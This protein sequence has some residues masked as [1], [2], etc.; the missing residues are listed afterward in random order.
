MENAKTMPRSAIAAAAVGIVAISAVLVAASADE[1]SAASRALGLAIFWTGLVPGA[2]HLLRRDLS[3]L[4]I[5][6]VA[7][8]FYS[9]TFG[10]PV[11]FTDFI[12]PEG[13]SEYH[14]DVCYYGGYCFY[15]I[16]FESLAEYANPSALA[17]AFAGV[18]A[19]VASFI[20]C[21]RFA[22]PR[23]TLFRLPREYSDRRLFL[24]LWAFLAVALA[25]TWIPAL[26]RLPS[27][28]QLITPAGYLAF[29]M[30]LVLWL[31]GRLG[32]LHAVFVFVFGLGLFFSN[33]LA[34]G[35]IT[36]LMILA[37]F[38]CFVLL[39]LNRRAIIG[40]AVIGI[41]VLALVYPAVHTYRTFAWS[42]NPTAEDKS[43]S[44]GKKLEWLGAVLV[45]HWRGADKITLNGVTTQLPPLPAYRPLVRRL[46]LLPVFSHVHRVTPDP[47]PYWGGKTYK[48]LLTSFIPRALW[49]GKPREIFGAEFGY[50]YG[51]TQNHDTSINI[52]WLIELF[53][54]FGALGVMIGM[55]AI[56]MFLAALDRFFNSP[57]ASSLETVIGLAIIVPLVYPNSN[58]SLMVGSLLPLTVSL[59]VYF[60]VGLTWR[61]NRPPA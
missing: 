59:W 33:K 38:L 32:R 44:V 35:L 20:A 37:L 13:F 50:R 25:Y 3:A 16:N 10:L 45:A 5:F 58:F 56:G 31:Q 41:I 2:W 14:N 22:A 49:P 28:G 51:F 34:G 15:S 48:P 26:R 39:Y 1:I 40:F 6:P 54:N 12:W 42:Q 52:P 8:A 11:F 36:P 60:R 29:G 27:V 17:V 47:V 21:R 43:P 53:I 57:G 61:A 46:A 4:P 7:G 23:I 18:A 19:F 55:A 9:V 24:L 30:F